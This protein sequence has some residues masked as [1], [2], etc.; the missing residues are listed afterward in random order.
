MTLNNRYGSGKAGNGQKNRIKPIGRFYFFVFILYILSIHVK[1][2]FALEVKEENKTPSPP[3]FE[4]VEDKESGR[5]PFL[6][7]KGVFL[8]SKLDSAAEKEK[9]EKPLELEAIITTSDHKRRATISGT[10]VE[11][12]DEIS[13]KKVLEIGKDFVVLEGPIENMRLKWKRPAFAI[14]ITDE[15][16]VTQKS[17]KTNLPPEKDDQKSKGGN[18]KGML[19]WAE[20]LKKAKEF[21]AGS[22]P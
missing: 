16:G 5:N 17:G 1:C 7:P 22:K 18:N 8:R 10:N 21:S 11:E 13:G 14:G 19:S 20:T 4:V 12:G 2:L 9:K 3:A 15:T 6:L